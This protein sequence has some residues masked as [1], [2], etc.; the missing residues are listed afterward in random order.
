MTVL[1]EVGTEFAWSS[2]TAISLLVISAVMWIL[3][4]VNERIFTSEKW[5]QEPIFPWRFF[6]NRAWMG[7]LLYVSNITPSRANSDKT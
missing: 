6:H 3:F 4:A 2:G 5:K 7:T 1:L